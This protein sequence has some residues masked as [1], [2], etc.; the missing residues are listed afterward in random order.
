MKLFLEKDKNL[1]ELRA[2]GKRGSETDLLEAHSVVN[3]LAIRFNLLLCF[4]PMFALSS[5]VCKI[6][7]I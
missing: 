6:E 5:S 7:D 3:S 4:P 2:E 1:A